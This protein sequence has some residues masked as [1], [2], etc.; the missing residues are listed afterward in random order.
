[1]ANKYEDITTAMSVLTGYVEGKNKALDTGDVEYKQIYDQDAGGY[2]LVRKDSL[3]G[4]IYQTGPVKKEEPFDLTASLDEISN[5]L[6]RFYTSGPVW[7]SEKENFLKFKGS[8]SALDEDAQKTAIK[9]YKKKISEN[10][11]DPNYVKTRTDEIQFDAEAISLGYDTGDEFKLINEYEAH[12]QLVFN[13]TLRAVVNSANGEKYAQI[14]RDAGYL[15]D[16][17]DISKLDF[18]K[19]FDL[20]T[21]DGVNKTFD[22][23]LQKIEEIALES[24]DKS[25]L[26]TIAQ[27]KSL[28]DVGL[29]MVNLAK[30]TNLGDNENISST[31]RTQMKDALK[32]TYEIPEDDAD[33]NK[34]KPRNITLSEEQLKEGGDI[35]NWFINNIS[36]QYWDSIKDKGGQI[37]PNLTDSQIFDLQKLGVI[38]EDVDAKPGKPSARKFHFTQ[39]ELDSPELSAL[40]KKFN[41]KPA[42]NT[43]VS[44]NLTDDELNQIEALGF[45]T[46]WPEKE[47]E[48]ID[49]TSFAKN[50]NTSIIATGFKGSS[51]SIGGNTLKLGDLKDGT[52]SEDDYTIIMDEF[53][54][55]SKINTNPAL[56]QKRSNY[57]QLASRYWDA[58]KVTDY[59]EGFLQTPEQLDE[60][61]K[62][63]VDNT[64][65]A[66][67]YGYEGKDSG[68]EAEVFIGI[69]DLAL[70][71]DKGEIDISG[72]EKTL[73]LVGNFEIKPNAAGDVLDLKTFVSQNMIT[74]DGNRIFT[75]GTQT[76]INFKIGKKTYTEKTA[77]EALEIMVNE[78]TRIWDTF[79]GMSE[80]KRVDNGSLLLLNYGIGKDSSGKVPRIFFFN[81]IPAPENILE[82]FS[83]SDN[84]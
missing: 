46:G 47:E 51:F 72:L 71:I 56:T 26:N 37:K 31:F 4:Q 44:L 54:D 34:P 19:T 42:A 22:E 60:K 50:L 6:D 39:K 76:T 63:Y 65:I 25:V 84:Q 35:E 82:L 14:F 66:L 75:D 18:N 20:V 36:Q 2:K 74:K 52:I 23:V 83:G 81:D 70:A 55:L 53:K 11:A 78:Y 9:E 13:G 32:A 30:T 49:T 21:A 33:S 67:K 28:S 41:K 64:K 69:G 43:D 15:G 12:G 40:L 59:S 48:K 61:T 24:E 68:I 45:S 8:L 7:K 17:D 10:Y 79:D 3:V 38:Y 73:E 58:A 27:W 5:T 80:Q 57:Q 29:S 16:D 62:K 1:M 77:S